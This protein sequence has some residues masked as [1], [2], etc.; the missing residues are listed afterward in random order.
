[1]AAQVLRVRARL[2]IATRLNDLVQLFVGVE[3]EGFDAVLKIG[4]ANGAHGLDRVHEAQLCL[5]QKTP[6]QAHLRD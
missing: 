1:M 5:A 2:G 6:H 3:R 4:L